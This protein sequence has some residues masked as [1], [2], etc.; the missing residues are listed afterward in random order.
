[1]IRPAEGSSEQDQ[2][3]DKIDT[4]IAALKTS[5]A[6]GF[7]EMNEKMSSLRDMVQLLVNRP[8]PGVPIWVV[9]INAIPSTILA[10]STF[11][12]VVYL[13]FFTA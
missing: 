10:I 11:A 8:P 2:R 1:M 9:L 13:I 5:T 7:G 6:Y 3:L 12:L 4:E